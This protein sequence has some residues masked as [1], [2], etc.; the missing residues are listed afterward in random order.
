M[1]RRKFAFLVHPRASIR[2]DLRRIWAPLGL[3]PD[4]FYTHALRNLPLPALPI[5]RVELADQPGE[6][7]GW[8]IIVPLGARQMLQEPRAWVQQKVAA[9]IDKAGELGAD[10]VGLGALTASVTGGGELFR[11]R[12]DIGVTNGNALTAVMTFDG[13]V[14]LVA[15][16]GLRRPH[17]A[18]V[19]AT[20]SVGS[21][22]ARLLA[23]RRITD[24]ISLVARTRPRL[25][26]LAAEMRECQPA[27]TITTARNMDALR[28]AD[29]VVLLTSAAD[30]LL[31]SEHLKPG[32][33]VLDD[34]QPR[35]THP[36]LLCER[37]DVLIVD[38]G[39]VA[40]PGM[41]LRGGSI[42][43]PR[44]QAYACLAETMLLARS[45]HQGHFSLGNPELAQLDH[46]AAL[47]C[48]EREL[49]FDLAPFQSFGKPLPASETSSNPPHLS[50]AM[51]CTNRLATMI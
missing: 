37:P 40:V 43:L 16:S 34:T 45:G 36:N 8:I 13:I 1:N 50:R 25:D 44:G 23:R 47:A 26:A 5:S 12:R 28:Q 22:V 31:R 35:N 14:S 20:G 39:I 9:A 11:E 30:A 19:G 17:I 15:R 27:A 49:G 46:I 4:T 18:L 21:A 38:G 41:R 32:A 7:A 51:D 42:G 10:V 2:D 29:L 48:R 33:I 6:T 24:R 3:L